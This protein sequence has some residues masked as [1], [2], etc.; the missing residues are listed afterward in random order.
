MHFGADHGTIAIR[1]ATADERRHYELERSRAAGMSADDIIDSIEKGLNMRMQDVKL[2]AFTYSMGDNFSRITNIRDVI[3]RGIVQRDGAG[4]HIGGG[5]RVYEAV[6]S[7]GIAA[8]AVPGIHRDTACIDPRMRYHS[9]GASPEKVGAAYYAHQQG[10][11][12]NFILCD[13]SS[14]TVTVG[15]ANKRIIGALDACIFA[16]GATQGPIELEDIR[17]IDAGAVTANEAFSKGGVLHKLQVEGIN[18]IS[19]LM[20]TC[21]EEAECVIDTIALHASME[22]R[23]ISILIQDRIEGGGENIPIYLSGSLSEDSRLIKGMNRYLCADTI[24]IGKWSAAEGCA[25]IARDIYERKTA[26]ILG[27]EVNENVL[28]R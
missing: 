13:I 14:N 22:A 23:A 6:E 2:A 12:D 25:S 24:S 26:N 21:T 5:T 11:H 7:A 18:T 3:G 15:V 28:G 17:R 19:E 9:H 8:V 27:I 20:S 1:F 16:P 4:T 10:G